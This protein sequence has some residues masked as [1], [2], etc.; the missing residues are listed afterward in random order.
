MVILS[1]SINRTAVGFCVTL[2]IRHTKINL[3]PAFYHISLCKRLFKIESNIFSV[4][5]CTQMLQYFYIFIWTTG[6][7]F[8]NPNR[9]GIIINRFTTGVNRT[10]KLFEFP[11]VQPFTTDHIA[12]NCADKTTCITGRK[13]IICNFQIA[14]P[15][16]ESDTNHVTMI[17]RFA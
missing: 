9:I 14:L 2:I 12:G 3:I 5:C 16:T 15:I 4:F 13:S 17:A 10:V 7:R 6:C 1:Q 8:V 11:G